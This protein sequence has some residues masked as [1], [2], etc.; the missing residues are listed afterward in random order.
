[1]RRETQLLPILSKSSEYTHVDELFTDFLLR[2]IMIMM[3]EGLLDDFIKCII[4]H[5]RHTTYKIFFSTICSLIPFAYFPSQLLEGG[6]N[7]VEDV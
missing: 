6:G 5:L 3:M 2:E 1:M 7:V 4:F